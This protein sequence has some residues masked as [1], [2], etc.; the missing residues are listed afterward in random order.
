MVCGRNSH[1]NLGNLSGRSLDYTCRSIPVSGSLCQTTS[2]IWMVCGSDWHSASLSD[3]TTLTPEILIFT[4]ATSARLDPPPPPAP[5]RLTLSLVRD[6]N[7]HPS[8]T[9]KVTHHRNRYRVTVFYY[10]INSHLGR[11]GCGWYSWGYC[12]DNIKRTY[13]VCL[14]LLLHFSASSLSVC[15]S[16]SLFLLFFVSLSVALFFFFS[17]CLCLSLSY[18]I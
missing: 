12:K 16:R 13:F 6:A 2:T 8:Q 14:F 15:L 9:H 17:P 4:P 11:G 10:F 18:S 3:R 7:T 1:K 5:F